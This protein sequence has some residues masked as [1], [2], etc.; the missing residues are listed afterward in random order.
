LGFA[1]VF[2]EVSVD[3]DLQVDQRVKDAA[4]QSTAG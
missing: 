1:V 2:A 4:L 3:R